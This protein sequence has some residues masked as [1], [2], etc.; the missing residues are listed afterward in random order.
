VRN[1]GTAAQLCEKSEKQCYTEPVTQ[2]E[3]SAHLIVAMTRQEALDLVRQF[4]Q[5]L[6]EA[7]IPFD[8]VIVFGSVARGTMHE[9]S[10]IDVAVVGTSFKGDRMEEALAVRRERWPISYKIQPIW[11][12]TE[13]LEN[14]YSTLATEIRREG[15]EV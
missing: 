6:Q 5:A 1:K 3:A 14:R 11:M 2:S 10:D 9:Q 12:Y 4:K 7:Q 15:V 8:S 13:N